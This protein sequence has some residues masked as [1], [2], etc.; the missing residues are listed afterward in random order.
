MLYGKK[1]RIELSVTLF[2]RSQNGKKYEFFMGQRE[3][4]SLDIT[5]DSFSPNGGFSF[6]LA[7][8]IIYFIR[9]LLPGV[10]LGILGNIFFGIN[11]ALAG[12]MIGI[13][14]SFALKFRGV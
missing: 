12:F 3:I 5:K 10:V 9:I 2:A 6:D 13:M 1:R 7:F 4:L 8:F 14:I 11:G